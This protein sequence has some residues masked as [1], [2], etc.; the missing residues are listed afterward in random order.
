MTSEA[1]RRTISNGMVHAEVYLPDP[2][3]GFYRG[4]R[5]DWA[6]IIGS[7][8]SGDHQYFGSW[9]SEH[10]PLKHDCITGPAEEFQGESD[11]DVEYPLVD[12]GAAFLR[13]GVGFF[14]DAHARRDVGPEIAGLGGPGHDVAQLVPHVRPG[15]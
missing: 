4:T 7:L 2:E 5:F 3:R 15:A 10:D 12:T 6:G 13:L 8:T 9:Y 1:P 11:P 14:R